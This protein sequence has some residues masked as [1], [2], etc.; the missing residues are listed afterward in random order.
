MLNIYTQDGLVFKGLTN[1]QVREVIAFVGKV[2]FA[3][4]DYNG[5]VQ[6]DHAAKRPEV[7][8]E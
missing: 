4:G 1:T 7:Q 6:C 3:A 5:S 2:L 8:G